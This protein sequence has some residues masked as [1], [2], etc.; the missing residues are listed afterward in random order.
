MNA[1]D[2]RPVP[3][4]PSARAKLP[5]PPK[6]RR[7]TLR[8][9]PLGGLGEV[10]RNM[11]V[12]EIDGRLLIVDCGVLFPEDHQPGVDLV[13]PDFELIRDRLGDVEALI[14][15]HGHEDH[16][17]GVPYLLRERPDLPIVG[18]RLTLAMTEAKLREHRIR[19]L[20]LTVAERTSETFGP[21]RCEFVAV[22]H[23]IPDA[24]AVAVHT[25][26]GSVLHTG[27]FKLDP[28][29]LDGRVTD[30]R[31]LARLGEAGIDLLMIDS[32]NAEVAGHV[33]SE[34]EVGPALRRAV[35]ETRGIVVAAAFS[36]HVHRVQQLVDAAVANRRKVAFVGRSMLRTMTIAR[37]LG[38]L[39]VPPDTV[40]DIRAVADLP[41]NR[42]VVIST[43][44]QGEPLSALA[45][46]AAGSHAQVTLGPT[47]TVLLAAGT[48]PGTE[49]AV[50]RVINGIVGCGSRIV[51][52]DNAFVHVSGHARAGELLIVHDTVKPRQ[53][54]PVH[55]ELRHLTANA[56]LA[57]STGVDPEHVLIGGN[58]VSVD[59][60]DGKA[61]IVGAVPC[62]Y[63]YVD[64]RG[65]GEVDEEALRERVT[66]GEE[67]FVL[68]VA[69][70]DAVGG[71]IVSGPDV[72]SHGFADNP[73]MLD[74]VRPKITDALERAMSAGE[75]EPYPLQQAIRRVVGRW[76]SDTHRRRPVIIPV[77]V[78]T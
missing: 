59:M 60:T 1:I 77:V 7:G 63:L 20:E 37:E 75:R 46:M 54:M 48:V 78:T 76:A 33:P 73:A 45:R 3:G 49:V 11:T 70:V 27:D 57:V 17:G 2:T 58:G 10:G 22:N 47:D 9:T 36:S 18:T 13:L 50:S 71:R 61:E 30:L 65:V 24:V 74:D 21:F 41:R 64:G 42:V 69:V 8:I 39:T 53:T 19:P 25:R 40:V 5:A 31:H 43:G 52:R 29:P 56:G 67:G 44:S 51:H 23:S 14:L 66:L 62:G 68:V 34:R 32:T 6:L 26:A 4:S 28:T 38:F 72:S 12:F 35:A 55:G 16:I 15:T